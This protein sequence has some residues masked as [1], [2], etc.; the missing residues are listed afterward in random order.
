VLEPGILLC[1]GSLPKIR[2][3]SL[4]MMPSRITGRWMAGDGAPGSK[5]RQRYLGGC[6]PSRP[7]TWTHARQAMTLGRHWKQDHRQPLLERFP[8][9]YLQLPPL[10]E[11][12]APHKK[13]SGP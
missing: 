12:L 9:Q 3:C 8:R 2:A 4:S 10:A 7:R 13:K 1:L 6:G 11:V 5:T